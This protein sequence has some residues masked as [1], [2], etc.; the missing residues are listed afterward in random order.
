MINGY[1]MLYVEQGAGESVLFV[2]GG[3]VDHRTWDEHRRIIASHYRA[4]AMKLRYFGTDD[5]P[6]DG[7]NFSI[8]VHADDLAA[9][10]RSSGVEPVTLVGWSYSG[11]VCLVT[12]I[13]NRGL[14]RRMFLYEPS[15][16]TFVTQP[17]DAKAAS[18]DRSA[19]MH[20]GKSLAD[21]GD[22]VGAARA[23][24]D[25][26]N[27]DIGTFDRMPPAVRSM[28]LDNLR[29]LPA[30]LAAPPPP[31][32]T[33]MDLRDLDIPVAIAVGG[34]ARIF[35]QIVARTAQELLPSAEL[36]IV[37]N[38]KHIW[39]LEDPTEFS[40]LLLDFLDRT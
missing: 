16:A 30:S 36:K 26:V 4:I 27:T 24:V 19:M 1:E 33:E 13:Q 37:E 11:A 32:V 35:Y 8:Q 12:A 14:I 40:R 7:K 17:E 5:W 25:A 15:L 28:L 39:P 38:G 20:D 2:H 21:A 3:L 9:F 23:Y 29:T 22:L 18:D 10:A 6:D 34:Q 31:P